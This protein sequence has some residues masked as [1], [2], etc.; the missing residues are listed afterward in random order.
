MLDTVAY[1]RLQHIHK[2]RG[3][4]STNNGKKYMQKE[5]QLAMWEGCGGE[6]EGRVT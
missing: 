4:R 1:S 6:D 5:W 2:D 3:A